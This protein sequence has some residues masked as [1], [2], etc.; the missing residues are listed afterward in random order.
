MVHPLILRCAIFLLP[1]LIWLALNSGFFTGKIFITGDNVGDFHWMVY[2]FESLRRGTFP[3]W[4]PFQSWGTPEGLDMR[5]IGDFNPYFLLLPLLTSVGVGVYSA[6]LITIVLY[7]WLGCLGFYLLARHITGEKWLAFFS[8]VLFMF[9]GLGIVIFEQLMVLVTLVPTIWFF[10][11]LTGFIRSAGPRDRLRNVLGIT[12]CLMVILTT[13][14]PFFFLTVFLCFFLACLLF[15]RNWLAQGLQSAWLFVRQSPVV[16]LGCIA[17][18][19]LCTAPSLLWYKDSHSGDYVLS[20]T[21]GPAGSNDPLLVDRHLA[22]LSGLFTETSWQEFFSDFDTAINFRSYLPVMA[23][24]LFLLSFLNPIRR[25]PVVILTT[26]LFLFLVACADVAAVHGFLYKHFFIFRAFRNLYFFWQFLAGAAAL[27]LVAELKSFLAQDLAGAQSRRKRIIYVLCMHLLFLA[28]LLW[29]ENVPTTSFVTVGLSAV[30][31]CLWLSGFLRGR[32]NFFVLG[33]TAIMLIQPVQVLPLFHSFFSS[34]KQF[35]PLGGPVFSYVR[36]LRGSG[37]NEE[38]GFYKRVKL[39]QEE[40][41]FVKTGYVGTEGSYRLQSYIPSDFLENYVKHKFVLYDNTALMDFKN[42]EWQRLA[43]HLKLFVNEALVEDAKALRPA[44][45]TKNIFERGRPADSGTAEL[46]V[47]SFSLNKILIE[48]NF[49]QRKFLVYN[50]S[51]HAGWHTFIDGKKA[52]LYRANLAFKGIWV[53]AGRHQIE[54]TFLPF[55]HGFFI[56]L[57]IFFF[58]WMAGLIWCFIPRSKH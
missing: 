58:I 11:F 40:S 54:M 12:F 37:F 52:A 55:R 53:E 20:M 43:L 6:F 33:L 13:Y 41:G 45:E 56:F 16:A 1:F 18:L 5:Y 48:T 26:G 31:F 32:K 21:R 29:L 35:H 57:A 30:W 17:A 36:P 46:K 4:V 3:L 27:L 23:F 14:I 49:A 10:V 24:V 7:F 51:F 42:P 44:Q 38:H 2:H 8:Y 9:S 28:F 19:L 22:D 39:F 34:E 47:R 25:T 15:A 50:D